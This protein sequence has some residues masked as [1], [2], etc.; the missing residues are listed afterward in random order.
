MFIFVLNIGLPIMKKLYLYFF[1][2]LVCLGPF[3]K[4]RNWLSVIAI[5]LSYSYTPCIVEE[6]L[7]FFLFV[8]LVW[9]QWSPVDIGVSTEVASSQSVWDACHRQ[10]AVLL[11]QW[12]IKQI[13]SHVVACLINLLKMISCQVH[14][15]LE[16]FFMTAFVC[17]YVV[18]LWS[19]LNAHFHMHLF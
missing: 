12:V 9:W 7:E 19:H 17:I 14:Y 11:S 13:N 1:L 3:I 8:L 15:F 16:V 2:I 4:K 18:V 5:Y 6:K 10:G